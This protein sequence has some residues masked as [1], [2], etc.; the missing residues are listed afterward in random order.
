MFKDGER[1]SNLQTFLLADDPEVASKALT[2]IQE[3]QKQDFIQIYTVMDGLPITVRLLDPP[4]HE[5]LPRPETLEQQGDQETA[6]RVRALQEAN[7]MF[8]HRGCRLGITKPELTRVQARALAEAETA[9]IS[10]G[11]KT[12]LEIMIPLVSSE[13]ELIHQIEIVKEEFSLVERGFG[14][15]I[16]YSIGTMIELHRSCVIAD[17]LAADAEFFSFGTNDLT[18]SVYGLSRDDANVFLTYYIEHGI[19]PND[20]FRTIDEEGVGESIKMGV[21]RGRSTRPDLKIGA[22]GEHAG[23]PE[24]IEFFHNTGLDYVSCKIQRIPTATV[25]AAQVAIK[26]KTKA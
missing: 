11:V 4:L 23:D 5:F 25:A 8:G 22:C 20:P 21:A 10:M 3:F 6:A 7:P 12:I 15:H 17:K 2:R 26:N 13:K 18:A 24:S 1:L 9:T 16:P 19:F 14:K